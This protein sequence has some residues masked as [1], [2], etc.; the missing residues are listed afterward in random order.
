MFLGC[1]KDPETAKYISDL[2]GEATINKSMSSAQVGDHNMRVTSS[3]VNR[4]VMTP[5][6]VMT[7]PRS[8]E[9]VFFAEHQVMTLTK[10]DFTEHPMSADIVETNVTDHQ[11]KIDFPSLD[12]DKMVIDRYSNYRQKVR[13]DVSNDND[14]ESQ[15]KEQRNKKPRGNK[16][17]KIL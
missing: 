3:S 11:S 9:L 8:Q 13:D 10:M 16:S 4:M 1:G 2:T 17:P 15:T 6:Q 7:M 14:D 5:N 12:Y